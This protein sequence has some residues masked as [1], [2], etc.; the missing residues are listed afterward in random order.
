MKTCSF[1]GCGRS[2]ASLGL[3]QSHYNQ[4]RAGIPLKPVRAWNAWDGEFK[5]CPTCKERKPRSAFWAPSD[6]TRN[7]S[8][9]SGCQGAAHRERMFGVSSRSYASL[10]EAQGGHCANCPRTE[11]ENGK[12][13]AVDHNHACCPGRKSCG[14][15]VRGLLCSNC[16]KALGLVR[17]SVETLRNMIEYVS[18]NTQS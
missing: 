8:V 14:E 9:C 12:A 18:R 15:C 7:P 2:V 3:C 6:R 4:H 10:L 13:L 17:D 11:A 16:N 5:V 1:D